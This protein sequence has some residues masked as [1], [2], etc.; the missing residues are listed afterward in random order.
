MTPEYAGSLATQVVKVFDVAIAGTGLREDSARA[1]GF[2]P[3]A[4]ASRTWDRNPYYPGATV[5]EIKL[6]GEQRSGRLL[7]ALMLGHLTAQ[8]PERLDILAAAL[9]TEALDF[10][11]HHEG[12]GLFLLKDFHQPIR[13]SADIRRRLRDLY[14]SCI[15]TGKFVV[16]S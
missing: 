10:V 6:L 13:D 3:L 5:V 7:G 4:V 16:I 11:S 2:E 14:E 15:D 12:P 8:I 9:Y 1:A